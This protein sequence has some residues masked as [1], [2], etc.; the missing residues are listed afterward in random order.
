MRLDSVKSFGSLF[1]RAFKG[2]SRDAAPSM[3]AALAFYTLFSMAPLLVLAI[4][5]AGF[6]IGRDAAQDLLMR[7][8]SG[9]LGDTGA[10]GVKSVLDATNTHRNGAI[11]TAVSVATLA[12][13]ATTVFAEL[14][15]DLDRI[16]H[17]SPDPNA[18][19]W[20]TV[21]ARFLS[22][23]M[24][25]AIGF[26]LLVSLVASA[27][28]SFLG[29]FLGG[30]EAVL[31]V[32]ELGGSIAVTTG[33]FALTFKVLPSARIAWRDVWLGSFVTAVLFSIGKFLIGLY[34]GKSAVA[35]SYG[36]GGTLVVVIVWVYYSAQIFFYG[37]EFTREHARRSGTHGVPQEAANSDF[38]R[39][40]DAMIARAR[41]IVKGND[42]ALVQQPG[43]TK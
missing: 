7:E 20:D 31:H 37:A 34:L 12:L 21:R 3:G 13:G 27:A 32:L 36:A 4:A 11:A 38:V 29:D 10:Q 23:G 25:L 2:W 40:D 6:V 22:F 19:I 14:R 5:I 15:T 35:S 26:L 18:G 42:P 9:L 39:E 24:V 43:A 16:W 1:V 8:L 30:S 41:R 17:C 28:I 33:L